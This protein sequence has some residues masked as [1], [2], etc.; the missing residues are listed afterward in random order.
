[1]WQRNAL[2]HDVNE[3]MSRTEGDIE[4][5]AFNTHGNIKRQET[6]SRIF[7]GSEPDFDN[8]EAIA[9]ALVKLYEECNKNFFQTLLDYASEDAHDDSMLA[10]HQM[11]HEDGFR[12]SVACYSRAN[13]AAERGQKQSLGKTTP[14]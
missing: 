13:Q 6:P 3:G 10:S 8:I 2:A 14:F 12:G 11:S 1:M 5:L 4:N 9:D 7:S